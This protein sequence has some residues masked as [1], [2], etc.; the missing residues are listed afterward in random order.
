MTQLTI[1]AEFV[2]IRARALGRE[3]KRKRSD[4]GVLDM[5]V[6]NRKV[7]PRDSRDSVLRVP[8]ERD[9]FVVH[10]RAD[11][12]RA[13]GDF[14]VDFD[15]GKGPGPRARIAKVRRSL[16]NHGEI[17]KR[18]LVESRQSGNLRHGKRRDPRGLVADAKGKVAGDRRSRWRSRRRRWLRGWRW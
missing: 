9:A 11:Q 7:Q 12:G 17:V 13:A 5:R 4:L 1:V 16:G 6:L 15:L 14:R 8:A 10:E 2:E 3:A 18:G